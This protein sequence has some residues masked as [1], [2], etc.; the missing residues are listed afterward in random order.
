MNIMLY[1]IIV[2]IVFHRNFKDFLIFLTVWLDI[3]SNFT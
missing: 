2:F 3:L 1:H